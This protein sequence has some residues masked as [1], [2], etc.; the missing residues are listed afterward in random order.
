MQ[1]DENRLQYLE[2]ASHAQGVVTALFDYDGQQD[3]KELQSALEEFRHAFW[4]IENNSLLLLLGYKPSVFGSYEQLTTLNQAWTAEER[5]RVISLI[6]NMLSAPI[7]QPR[8]EADIEQLS[9]FFSKLAEY[10][11]QNFTFS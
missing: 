8:N 2:L 9:E 4:A 10:A 1:D 11:L 7:D 3:F 5:L 6:E